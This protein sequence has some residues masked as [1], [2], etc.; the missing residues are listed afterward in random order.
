MPRDR[1]RLINEDPWT[2]VG[3]TCA[4]VEVIREVRL[5]DEK[6]WFR[7]DCL[8]WTAFSCGFQLRNM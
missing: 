2:L 1:D 5:K 6:C 8:V 4:K 7:I 3:Y